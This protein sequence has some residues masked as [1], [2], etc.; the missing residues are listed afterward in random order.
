M[1]S[2]NIIKIVECLEDLKSEEIKKRA[3]AVGSLNVIAETFGPE[4]VRTNLLPFLKEYED[5]EEEVMLE[6]AKQ[7]SNLGQ[8]LHDKIGSGAD[9]IPYY[10]YV[11]S[12]EDSSVVEL[13]LESLKRLIKSNSL[14]T[15]NLPTLIK[16]LFT[17]GYPKAL[18]SASKLICGLIEYIPAKFS[19]EI[20]KIITDNT[21]NKY[22]PVRKETAVALRELLKEGSGYETLALNCLKKLVK[23]SQDSTRVFALESLVAGVH[24]KIYFMNNVFPIIYS[25]FGCKS[26]RCRYV[27]A[28]A[29]PR[30][31]ESAQT[32]AKKQL[33]DQYVKMFKDT[34][35]EISMKSLEKLQEAVVHID[36]DDVTS[37]VI[38]VLKEIVVKASIETRIAISSSVL[39]LAPIIGKNQSTDHIKEILTHLLK[40]NDSRIKVEL[41]KNHKPLAQVLSSSSLINILNPILKDLIT[42]KDWNVRNKGLQAYDAYLTKLGEDYCSSDTVLENI[43]SLMVDRI[44]AVRKSAISLVKNLC[45]KFGVKWTEK[46]GLDIFSDFIKHPFYI[47]RLNYV[48]GIRAI[49]S[50]LSTKRLNGEIETLSKMS[51]DGVANVRF[52]ALLTLMAIYDNTNDKDLGDRILKLSKSLEKD[53]DADIKRTVGELSSTPEFKE[54]IKRLVAE[55]C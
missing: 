26:W 34:E 5:D 25:C 17:V 9:V 39:Y 19:N 11:L 4:K 32:N 28:E 3:Q 48:F 38:P 41:F 52:N 8:Y 40:D 2:K 31:L 55:V 53:K 33:I 13:G 27:L 22:C 23:D 24:S 20:N 54:N 49:F 15:D 29:M 46:Y 45:I 37:K 44:F 43:K 6:L 47:Y 50:Q 36:A 14:K 21:N 30:I 7:L 18:I 51:K 35:P 16:R 42:D 10:F 1:S 12:Y